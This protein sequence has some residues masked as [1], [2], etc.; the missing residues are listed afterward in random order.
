MR[1]CFRAGRV[2]QA[3]G[4]RRGASDGRLMHSPGLEPGRW[5]STRNAG[6]GAAGGGERRRA[7]A[8]AGQIEAQRLQSQKLT[9]ETLLSPT[10]GQLLG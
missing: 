5:P 8:E 3:R 9:K 4:G 7:A 2:E 1:F 10:V 6:G